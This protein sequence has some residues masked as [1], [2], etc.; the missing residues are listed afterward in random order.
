[1]LAVSLSILI[2][3]STES[4]QSALTLSIFVAM[5]MVITF[6]VGGGGFTGSLSTD[7]FHPAFLFFYVCDDLCSPFVGPRLVAA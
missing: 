7:P 6:W 3:I 1:M 4:S 5:A 2:G